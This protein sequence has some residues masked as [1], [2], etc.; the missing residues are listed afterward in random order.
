MDAKTHST[1]KSTNLRLNSQNRFD[2][3]DTAL[4]GLQELFVVD[5]SDSQVNLRTEA[6]RGLIRN[7]YVLSDPSASCNHIIFLNINR[8]QQPAQRY[9][10][11]TFFEKENL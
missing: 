10:E 5:A 6:T 4:E 8:T 2:A 7:S 3:G 9:P 11:P 1:S